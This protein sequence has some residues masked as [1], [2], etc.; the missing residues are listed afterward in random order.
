MA[1]QSL[2]NL[3]IDTNI[4]FEGLT[5]QGSAS[6]LIIEAWLADVFKIHVSNAIAYEYHDVLTRK[7]SENRWQKI[8][9]ILGTLL[10][11]SEF[12]PIYYSWRPT[13][14]DPNDDLIID[15]A[16]NANAAIVTSNF[17]DFQTAK[18]SLGLQIL[19]P[20]QLI[21]QITRDD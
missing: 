16:M 13:S 14:P 2:L 12:T 18:H 6:G 5:K 7:L 10:K 19:T 21:L 8:K 15:C 20:V 3:V 11:H 1:K 9:P 4:V 17:R